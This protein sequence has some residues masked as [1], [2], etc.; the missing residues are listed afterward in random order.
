MRRGLFQEAILKFSN[1][2]C[3]RQGRNPSIRQVATTGA[4]HLS[5]SPG[6]K[7]GRSAIIIYR[8]HHHLAV[9]LSID[10]FVAQCRSTRIQLT[11]AL[12]RRRDY[13]ACVLV[14]TLPDRT[15]L[16]PGSN[17]SSQSSPPTTH[18]H[19]QASGGARSRVCSYSPLI[20]H[21]DV[22]LLEVP[23]N[24]KGGLQHPP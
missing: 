15:L 4:W 9:L 5:S 1:L 23:R 22:D 8:H 21:S 20:A 13:R 12:R 16:R 10:T 11:A 3:G 19:P 18:H 7:A 17:R 14:R 24:N 2:F 6:S